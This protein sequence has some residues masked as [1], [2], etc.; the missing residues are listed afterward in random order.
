[1]AVRSAMHQAGAAALTNPLQFPAPAVGQRNLP[2]TCGHHARYRELHY[3]PVLTALG[4]AEVSRPYAEWIRNIADLQSPGAIQ[5]VD[6]YCL[7][8]A[9]HTSAPGRLVTATFNPAPPVAKLASGIQLSGSLD[10]R[11]PNRV[12][13]KAVH[14]H[15]RKIVAHR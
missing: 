14:D 6:L 3:K 13:G 1:M 8:L 9:Q 5:I 2:C 4:Q 15:Q 11:D 10:Y 7:V 12:A